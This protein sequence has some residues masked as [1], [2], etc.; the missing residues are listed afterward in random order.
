MHKVPVVGVD[1]ALLR[2]DS[3]SGRHKAASEGN[4][5]LCVSDSLVAIRMLSSRV[6]GSRELSFERKKERL[7]WTSKLDRKT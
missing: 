2:T 1:S 5:F 6:I 4:V 7:V 3:E